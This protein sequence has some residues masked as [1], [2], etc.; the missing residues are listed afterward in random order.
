MSPWTR[1]CHIACSCSSSRA[2]RHADSLAVQETLSRHEAAIKQA[3]Q[4]SGQRLQQLE[5]RLQDQAREQQAATE[6]KLAAAESRL[7][8]ANAQVAQLL[9]QA[10]EAK[11]DQ[12]G[13]QQ[14][15]VGAAARW[16]LCC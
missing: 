4:E 6:A 12:A 2:C 8:G 3:E 1:I 9:A 14:I 5:Q 10:D 11:Q 15:Q 7:A 13:L 16:Q